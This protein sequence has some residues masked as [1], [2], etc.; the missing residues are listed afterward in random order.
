[1]T[2]G[3]SSILT[4]E[5]FGKSQKVSFFCL[6]DRRCV[7]VH[8]LFVCSCSSKI[9]RRCSVKPVDIGVLYFVISSLIP[10]LVVDSKAFFNTPTRPNVGRSVIFVVVKPV[11][12]SICCCSNF[13]R[14]SSII[15]DDDER[16]GGCGRSSSVGIVEITLFVTSRDRAD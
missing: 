6:T 9:R 8:S 12:L 13:D 16:F 5:L 2:Q 10:P 15:D 3:E 11:V 1:M 4:E 14:R 7:G